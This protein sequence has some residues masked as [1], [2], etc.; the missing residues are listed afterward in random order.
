[1]QSQ[2]YRPWCEAEKWAQDKRL[3][4]QRG[5]PELESTF[6]CLK[7]VT[8]RSRKWSDS[9]KMS[10]HSSTN[11][12]SLLFHR[13][14]FIKYHLFKGNLYFLKWAWDKNRKALL[15]YLGSSIYFSMQ[16][17][18]K[19]EMN[20]LQSWSSYVSSSVVS[21]RYLESTITSGCYNRS[22]SSSS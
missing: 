12:P 5:Y 13:V 15:M 22:A 7:D 19:E 3:Q 6:K 2:L 18:R 4:G 20:V 11:Q 14:E 8:G 17:T 1:M 16:N 10:Q 21:R 9:D